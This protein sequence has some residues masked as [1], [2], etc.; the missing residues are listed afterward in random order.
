[1]K[2][3]DVISSADYLEDAMIDTAGIVADDVITALLQD[4]SVYVWALKSVGDDYP[5][6]QA[7]RIWDIIEFVESKLPNVPET[8]YE[9]YVVY[10]KLYSIC[11]ESIK[12]VK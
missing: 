1:M 9:R 11:M 3:A 10:L 2:R 8:I 7:M 12:E 5:L 4:Y 6:E